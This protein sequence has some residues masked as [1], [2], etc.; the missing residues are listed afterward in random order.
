[1]KSEKIAIRSL[2]GYIVLMIISAL[3]LNNITKVV[4]GSLMQQT[5][6]IILQAVCSIY[7]IYIINRFY[8]WKNIG[9]KKINIKALIWFVPH[10]SIILVMM[11][12]FVKGVYLKS[13]SLN[14]EIWIILFMN[15]IGC[16]LAGASEE[17]LFR[18][19]MLNSFQNKKSI[20]KPMIMGSLGFG[21][22]H[23]ATVLLGMPLIDALAGVISSCLIGFALVVLTIKINNIVPAIIYH[24]LWNF[25][26]I[27]SNIVNIEI[28]KY[29][30][31]ENPTNI[32]IGVILGIIV[33]REH[34][35]NNKSINF[36]KITCGK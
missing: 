7:L 16:V 6:Q 29:Y 31:L 9:F 18:G 30:L 25:I 1:M 19:I 10:M 2:V 23:I 13:P 26:L 22:V 34:K 33:I 28:S 3:I 21:V 11:Y 17:I 4:N 35:Y 14:N 36:A 24:I 12:T 20:A 15:F 8:G 32:A 27:G 5:L